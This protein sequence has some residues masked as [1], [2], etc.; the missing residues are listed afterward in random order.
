MAADQVSAEAVAR[1][2]RAFEVQRRADPEPAERGQGQGFVR[3]IHGEGIGIEFDHGQAAAVD[4]NAFAKLHAIE[5]QR[6]DADAQ[7]RVAAAGFA[8]GQGA[9]AFDQSG[10][11]DDSALAWFE[12]GQ[13]GHERDRGSRIG[14]LSSGL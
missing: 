3:R 12:R 4:R 9:D 11:H 2:H 13:D 1:A 7:A 8:R 6:A 10:E 5:R 14:L